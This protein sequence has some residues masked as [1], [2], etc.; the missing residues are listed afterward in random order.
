MKR[1]RGVVGLGVTLLQASCALVFTDYGLEQ[2]PGGGGGAGGEAPSLPLGAACASDSE[3]IGG[4]CVP[5]NDDEGKVCC[6]DECLADADEP[7]GINGRCD[8]GGTACASFPAETPCGETTCSMGLETK[9]ECRAGVCV[10]T[11]PSPCEGGLTCADEFACRSTCEVEEDCL[12]PDA[13]CPMPGSPFCKVGLG[14]PCIAGEQ[15]LSG[16]CGP[17]DGG[18]CCLDDTCPTEDVCGAV[19]CGEAGECIFASELTPCGADSYC[20]AGKLEAQFCTGAGACDDEVS[21]QPCPGNLRCANP[22]ACHE[23]CGS[24]D[25]VGDDRCVSGYWCDGSTC[26]RA[27]WDNR[28]ACTRN[29]Q[30]KS[31]ICVDGECGDLECDVDGDGQDRED[32]ACPGGTDCDDDDERV[33]VG[34]VEFF[35]VPRAIGSFDFDCDGEETPFYTTG[36]DCASAWSALLVPSGDAGCGVE[37]NNH[38]CYLFWPFCFLGGQ[39]AD[40][41]VATQLCR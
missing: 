20:D 34:Q 6:A 21:Q 31:N 40:N 29:A 37:G 17:D 2:E 41:P 39:V 35:D 7:C 8:P 4:F 27:S 30:C 36:C 24:N 25:V 38:Q 14:E 3:C 16:V 22:F 26:R 1:V 23:T 11:V 19:D 33:F 9:R 5:S 18:H 28:T 32:A 10:D 12:D 13:S 15:C